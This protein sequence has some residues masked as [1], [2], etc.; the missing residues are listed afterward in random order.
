MLD[1]AL[2]MLYTAL[3]PKFATGSD[4]TPGFLLFV[5]A[6]HQDVQIL[7]KQRLWEMLQHNIQIQVTIQ[8]LW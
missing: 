6:A 7:R 2:D 1:I 8:Q 4:A 5:Q 3:D